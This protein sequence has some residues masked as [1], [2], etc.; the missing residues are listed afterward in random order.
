MSKPEYTSWREVFIP[1]DR[2]PDEGLCGR[3]VAAL[4][5]YHKPVDGLV[6]FFDPLLSSVA[7]AA[8]RLGLPTAPV[9]AYEIATDKHK[10]GEF[11]GH[12]AYRISSL[13]EALSITGS[14][15]SL[16]SYPLIMKPCSGWGSEGVFRA[17]TETDLVQAVKSIDFERHGS[18]V[19]IESYCEGP[20]VDV[21]FV[22]CDGEILFFEVS[23]DFPKDADRSAST[24]G[25]LQT[26]I[27][28]AN[29]LPSGLPDEE[30]ETLKKSLHQSLLRLGFES[31]FFH[32]EARVQGSRMK[33]ASGEKGLF[34]LQA[35]DETPHR[36]TLPRVW[37]IEINAR[38]PGL[39]AA[40]ASRA[41]YGIDF[42]GVSLLL[43]LNDKTATR[44]LAKPFTSNHQY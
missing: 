32:L 9:A 23:D 24:Q 42:W 33:Y 43:A 19:V 5:N 40:W 38:P 27:E 31:G 15:E 3:I 20:E 44:Q 7:A 25:H 13:E 10:T 14:E 35:K 17:E 39:Q 16:L 21:N 6:S 2:N 12:N 34:D 28:V 41:T 8:V 1:I 30:I 26:F 29:I 4:E 22:L 36:N 37:L 11:D 18:S